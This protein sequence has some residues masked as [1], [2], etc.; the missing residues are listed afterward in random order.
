MFSFF[1]LRRMALVFSFFSVLG[2]QGCAGLVAA[3]AVKAV[4]GS[5]R[6]AVNVGLLTEVLHAQSPTPRRAELLHDHVVVR[7][8]SVVDTGVQIT[9]KECHTN[10]GV[11]GTKDGHYVCVVV[12]NTGG[13]TQPRRDV[14]RSCLYR[15]GWANGGR[16]PTNTPKTDFNPP[17]QAGDGPSL[18]YWKGGTVPVGYMTKPC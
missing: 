8:P 15:Q 1:S 4:G 13:A 9:Q 3:G 18:G 5:D 14:G 12:N 16:Q 7:A 11:W 17:I 6:A 2:L 10:N